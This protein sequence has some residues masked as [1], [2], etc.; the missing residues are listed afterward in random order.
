M[1]GHKCE[2]MC[3]CILKLLDELV[4]EGKVLPYK[5]WISKTKPGVGLDICLETLLNSFVN[6]LHVRIY[7]D[8]IIMI[9]AMALA[10]MAEQCTT[11][12]LGKNRPC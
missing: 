12:S 8:Y 10:T 3:V 4:R 5:M 2:R 6:R 7:D 1:V 9:E 11:P